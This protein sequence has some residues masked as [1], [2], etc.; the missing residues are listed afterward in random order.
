M[1]LGPLFFVKISQI[2][3]NSSPISGILNCEIVSEVSA[4]F[5]N[6]ALPKGPPPP[7]ISAPFSAKAAWDLEYWRPEFRPRWDFNSLATCI[8]MFRN[9]G[10]K[11]PFFAAMSRFSP[12]D[13][14]FGLPNY[15]IFMGVLVILGEGPPSRYLRPGVFVASGAGGKSGKSKAN[16]RFWLCPHPEN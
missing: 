10:K 6:G 4:I 12:K 3:P 9:P 5:G 11:R 8:C 2:P 16:G 13:A 15:Q 1:R 7:G 14:N